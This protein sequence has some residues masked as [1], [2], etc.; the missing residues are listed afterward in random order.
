MV[1]PREAVRE[2]SPLSTPPVWYARGSMILNFPPPA[3]WQDFQLLVARWLEQSCVEGTVREYGR[4]GQRQY[5]VDVYGE[6]LTGGHLGVQCKQLQSGRTLLKAQVK[7]EVDDVL[8][9]R[10]KLDT[11]V[12]ATTVPED[13]ALHDAVTDLN[14]SNA[15]PFTVTY[16]SWKHFNDRLNRYNGLVQD[17]Y[18]EYASA[19]GSDQ[20]LEDLKALRTAFERPAFTDDF[21]H[22]LSCDD[23]IAGV[24]DTVF[25]LQSGLLRDR[26]S[27]ALIC[28]ALP[29][30]LLP[31]GDNKR[32]RADLLKMVSDLRVSAARDHKN[33]QLN[34]SA[35]PQY[36]ANRKFIIE[37]VNR[38]LAT[39]GVPKVVPSYR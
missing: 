9:F 12:I 29:Q 3:N 23:F 13:T 30:N 7:S 24:S 5:G 36:N 38:F 25:F 34:Q 32:M 1:G 33:G 27:G 10:P 8:H 18:K 6:L 20:Q 11:L 21:A 16:W 37:K 26:L 22:K 17:C 28:S 31:K 15:Y 39:R 35:A 4:L 2:H 19:F 14:Q